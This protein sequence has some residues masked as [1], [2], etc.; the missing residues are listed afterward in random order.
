MNRKPYQVLV[1]VAWL[2]LPLTVYRYW[3]VW[4]RLPEHMATHFN[5]SGQANGWM[6][7]TEALQFGVGITLLV[8]ATLTV[9]FYVLQKQEQVSDAAGWAILGI[10]TL[11][12]AVIFQANSSIIDYNLNGPPVTIGGRMLLVPSVIV[13]IVI[14][15]GAKRGKPLPD[16]AFIAEERQ[17]SLILG[18]ILMIPLIAPAIFAGHTDSATRWAALP[19]A[20]LLAGCAALAL[21][22]FQYRFSSTGVEVRTLGFRLRSIPAAQIRDYSIE[23][24]NLARGY[25]IRG[26]GGT[27][28]YTWGNKVV[29]IRT[30]A[31]DVYLGHD[32]PQRIIRDLDAVKQFVVK[33]S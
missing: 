5:A 26:V 19:V 16:A 22:G 4:D 23:S 27:R 30:A 20:V 6:T 15:M 25:G 10:A 13:L 9:I 18:F 29:H 17:S 2:T 14:Y 28:A 8:L 21:N 32:E 31:G 24:W 33:T 3:S 11:I 1:W 12:V 7:R